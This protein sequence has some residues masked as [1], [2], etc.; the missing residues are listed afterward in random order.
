[1]NVVPTHGSLSTAD[2][3]AH[4]LDQA[5]RKGQPQA[6][7]LDPVCSAPS[8]SNGSNSLSSCLGGMPWPCPS[9][10]SVTPVA[11][12]R[13]AARR[14]RPAVAV[15]LDRVREQVEQHL[16]EPLAGRRATDARRARSTVATSRCCWAASGPTSAE[17]IGDRPRRAPPARATA[18][19]S[20]L[21]I[22]EMSST[23]LISSSR[24]LAALDDLLDVSRCVG[25]QLASS[26]SSWPNPSTAFSGV[27]S[28][29]LIRDRNS[30]RD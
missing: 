3:P 5:L 13:L 11:R 10:S 20:P 26:S 16:L 21:S 17:R 9:P 14:D 29:W 27:R 2:R 1:M 19:A 22:R 12:R 24:W 28:S 18:P 4:R 30:F 6:R 8:R 7:A 15:V 23:S 25:V